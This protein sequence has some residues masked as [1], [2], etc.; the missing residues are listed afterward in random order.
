MSDDVDY[1][2]NPDLDPIERETYI[3]VSEDEDRALVHTDNP[4]VLRR[5]RALDHWEEDRVYRSSG[6]V[7]GGEGTVP[8]GALK[9][10]GRTWSS[11][12]LANI[13]GEPSNE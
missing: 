2:V 5:L 3:R 7:H 1:R 12:G 6:E 10:R 4:H 11:G 8:V 9:I 13:V